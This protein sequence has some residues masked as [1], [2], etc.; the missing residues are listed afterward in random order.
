LLYHI[1]MIMLITLCSW[2]LCYFN[3]DTCR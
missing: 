2:C 3:F 1:K